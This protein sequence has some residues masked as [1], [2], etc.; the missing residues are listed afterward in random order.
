MVGGRARRAK[1]EDGSSARRRC[2]ARRGG[3]TT[4]WRSR[5][6]GRLEEN[7]GTRVD[8]HDHRIVSEIAPA[9][10]GEAVR[11]RVE[12]RRAGGEPITANAG[13]R[14][15]VPGAGRG[16]AT[17]AGRDR[18]PPPGDREAT[19]NR[20]FS[21]AAKRK[22]REEAGKGDAP[23]VLPDADAG[24]RRAEV[25]ADGGTFNLSHDVFSLGRKWGTG[26]VATCGRD[27]KSDARDGRDVCVIRSRGR[28][29]LW[30]RI[31]HRL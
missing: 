13:S 29:S 24:V 11:R 23:V 7:E 8:F 20:L 21:R 4:G 6:A 25:D 16:R 27:G 1:G 2:G 30:W 12:R 19:A 9:L 3:W 31:F 22:T 28:D 26:G 10:A 14:G 17:F 5:G 15:G 18:A